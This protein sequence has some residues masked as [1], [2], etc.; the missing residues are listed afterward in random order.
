MKET[1]HERNAGVVNV[2][3]TFSSVG[4]L[5]LGLERAGMRVVAQAEVDPWRRRVLAERF[6][7]CRIYDDVKSVAAGV[8]VANA[9]GRRGDG[10]AGVAVTDEGERGREWRGEAGSVD[11]LAGGFPCQ[12]LSV[13]GKRRGLAGERSGL[14]FEFARIADEFRPRWLLVENVPG[15]LSSANGRD[16][17][18]VLATLADLG[19][20]LAWRVLDARFFGV[21]QRRRRVFIVGHLGGEPERAVRAVG[22]GGHGDSEARGCSWQGVASRTGERIAPTVRSHPRP[23]SNSDGNVVVNA[24]VKRYGKGTDSDATDAMV[25]G[26][27]GPVSHALTSAGHDASED[28]TGRGTPVIVGALDRQ[29]GGP[30]DGSAQS[31]HIIPT[32]ASSVSTLTSTKTGGYR[33]GAE[34]ADQLAPAPT[35]GVR[36]LTPVECERL[37]SWP[38]DWTA[39]DGADTPDSRRYAACGDGVVSNVAEWIARGILRE[40]AA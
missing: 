33:L 5:D 28:G 2:L 20:G 11:L 25:I 36:R 4:G 37:M 26:A 29:A 3:S 19:Y 38:D 16:M 34:E 24:L 35:G 27:T 13:A 9:A 23:G 17:G 31:G 22:A 39:I 30:D 7:G 15:L 12:D 8:P 10:G 21:P 18:V 14:F 6:P 1:P 32:Y 40:D